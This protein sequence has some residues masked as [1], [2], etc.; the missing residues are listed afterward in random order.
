MR[1]ASGALW[2][3]FVADDRPQL[4]LRNAATKS[5]LVAMQKYTEA[6]SRAIQQTTA[7]NSN[8]CCTFVAQRNNESAKV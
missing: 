8:I 2:I 3:C 7:G 1:A 5:K 4:H 6:Q